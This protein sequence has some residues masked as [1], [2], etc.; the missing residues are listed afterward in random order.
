MMELDDAFATRI[1]MVGAKAPPG[2]GVDPSMVGDVVVLPPMNEVP[3]ATG[4]YLPATKYPA[5]V[6]TT[7]DSNTV[8]AGASTQAV[9]SPAAAKYVI[10]GSAEH[11]ALMG[12]AVSTPSASPPPSFVTVMPASASVA[13]P[14]AAIA[15][16]VQ[17][18]GGSVYRGGPGYLER[19]GLE[20]R[21]VVKLLTL[22]LMIT[23]GL[24]M[25]WVLSYYCEAW[26]GGS[27]FTERQEFFARVVYPLGV[28]FVLWNIK[29]L[30]SHDHHDAA[31]AGRRTGGAA[32][33]SARG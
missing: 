32:P 26:V 21:E 25:H 30:M 8:F 4:L 20:R 12:G 3:A 2:G 31:G 6:P 28:L 16:Q 19:M 22:A 27:D 11:R 14:A 10:E 23:L 15:R 7:A 29:A 13:A 1:P 18:G 33:M 9:Y 17:S 24:S 5:S